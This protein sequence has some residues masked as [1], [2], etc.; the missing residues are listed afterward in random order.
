MGSFRYK[1]IKFATQ[2]EEIVGDELEIFFH[3]YIQYQFLEV[4]LNKNVTEPV[5]MK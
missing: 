3:F 4:L 2:Q 5:E 1:H